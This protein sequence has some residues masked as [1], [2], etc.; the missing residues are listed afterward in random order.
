MVPNLT[1]P[2]HAAP[3]VLRKVGSSMDALERGHWFLK[4]KQVVTAT[5]IAAICGLSPYR[6]A[7]DVW[8]DK[9]RDDIPPDSTNAAMTWGNRLEPVVAAAYTEQYGIKVAKAEF[10]RK[11]FDGVPAGC[12]Q[13]YVSE[14]GQINV[15]VKTARSGYAW[16]DPGSDQIPDYYLT[17]VTWQMG[18]AGQRMTHL[19]VLIG[20]SDFR[21]YNVPFDQTFFDSLLDRA[22]EFWKLVLSKT[23]PQTDGSVACREYFSHLYRK[24]NKNLIQNPSQVLCS[25]AV[26]FFKLQKAAKFIEAK[27]EELTNVIIS[28]VGEFGGVKIDG[29][30][31]LSIVRSAGR[32]SVS[33]KGIVEALKI[34]VPSAIM[35]TIVA[36]NTETG[37][38]TSSVRTYPE[39]E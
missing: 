24:G 10:I 29:I 31:K 11:D 4:R 9:T 1:T 12:T 13:D 32:E 21:I 5:D 17:Q 15:E 22:R 35:E 33:Y 25:N 3:G 27:K 23:P 8:L 34:H 14:D 2:P 28:E 36:A 30:G 18:I 37:E 19:A 38:P 20:A 7:F 39:K 16:G 26:K 6:S